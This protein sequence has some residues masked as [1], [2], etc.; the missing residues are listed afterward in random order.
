MS[1]TKRNQLLGESQSA[2]HVLPRTDR[3]VCK[4]LRSD[5]VAFLPCTTQHVIYDN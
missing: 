4:T 3:I 1:K 5:T 2:Q